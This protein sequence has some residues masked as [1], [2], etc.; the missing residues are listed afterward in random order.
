MHE[1]KWAPDGAP[2]P[3]TIAYLAGVFA[4]VIHEWTTE[5]EFAEICRRNEAEPSDLSC[6]THDFMDANEAMD[7]A[8]RRAFGR[9]SVLP[10]SVETGETTEAAVEA[11][12]LLWNAAWTQAKEGWLNTSAQQA[13]TDAANAAGGDHVQRPG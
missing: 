13:A 9:R 2:V 4:D 12:R 3:E 7:E 5:E 6:A 11:D 10:L 1:P 8:F